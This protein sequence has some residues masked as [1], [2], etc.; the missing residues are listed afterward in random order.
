M[1]CLCRPHWVLCISQTFTMFKISCIYSK[2]PHRIPQLIPILVLTLLTACH[3]GQKCGNSTNV[4]VWV[5]SETRGPFRERCFHCDSNS[6]EIFSS[7]IQVTLK[8]SLWNFVRDRQL[9]SRDMWK[10][11]SDMIPYNKVF[12]STNFSSN[13]KYDGKPGR[14]MDPKDPV[15]AEEHAYMCIA[16]FRSRDTLLWY[17]SKGCSYARELSHS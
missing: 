3:E 10:F 6:M 4:W 16:C 5:S 11:C 8:W 17:K 15:S 12:A 1:N 14:E 7:L 13:L 2:L 9:R